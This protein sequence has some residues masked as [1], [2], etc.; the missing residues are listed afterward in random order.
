MLDV[1][2]LRHPALTCE[3]FTLAR[4]ESRYVAGPSGSGKSLLLRAIA[5]LDPHEGEVV[6]NGQARSAMP[7]NE[8]RRR[9]AYLPAESGWW[10]ER[11]GAHFNATSPP[12]KLLQAVGMGAACLAWSVQRLSTGERQRLA[13]VRALAQQPE[14]L[15]L[16]EPTSA[17]DRD[18]ASR[19]EALL[20]E[21]RAQG[22]ALLVVSHDP[23]QQAA[24]G[25]R[26]LHV[27]HGR[28]THDG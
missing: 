21:Q 3:A 1:K 16:D 4:G 8:W 12:K 28:V 11:V 26:G 23:V 25:P 14:V 19:V 17:L 15:L 20:H 5:D 10:S 7:A 2:F 27:A 13:L 24:F 22:V 18:A 6:L 9:V